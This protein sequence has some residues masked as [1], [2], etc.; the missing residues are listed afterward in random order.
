MFHEEGRDPLGEV[1]PPGREGRG[2]T[3]E[4]RSSGIETSA[5]TGH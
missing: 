4:E 5:G 3:V 2:L 1:L